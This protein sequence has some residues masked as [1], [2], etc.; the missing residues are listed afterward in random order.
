MECYDAGVSQDPQELQ[1]D[2]SFV[3]LHFLRV[4]P[5][6]LYQVTDQHHLQGIYLFGCLVLYLVHLS[7]GSFSNVVNHCVVLE[8]DRRVFHNVKI[9]DQIDDIGDADVSF[10][11]SADKP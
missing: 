5:Q 2:K 8:L 4:S 3:Q 9:Y 6:Y 11:M 7:V 10:I 1:L